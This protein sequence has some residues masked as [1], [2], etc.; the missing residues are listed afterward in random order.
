MEYKYIMKSQVVLQV[1][2]QETFRALVNSLD[3]LSSLS[4]LMLK[5]RKNKSRLLEKSL[6]MELNSL[7]EF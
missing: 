2:N 7:L 1:S 6:L 4:S 3:K 5:R